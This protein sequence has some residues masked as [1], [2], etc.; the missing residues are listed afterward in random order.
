[1]R[2]FQVSDPKFLTDRVVP[3]LAKDIGVCKD[4]IKQAIV[5][6]SSDK[7]KRQAM[8]AQLKHRYPSKVRVILTLNQSCKNATGMR[9]LS[10]KK[11]C[12]MGS[13]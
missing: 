13:Q 5:Y 2:F 9:V 12:K 6:Q 1:M 8:D 4:E 10:V 7:A 11:V 3:D